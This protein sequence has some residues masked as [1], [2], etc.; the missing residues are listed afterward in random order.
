MALPKYDLR[1]ISYGNRNCPTSNPSK[2]PIITILRWV[3]F[4]PAALIGCLIAQIVFGAVGRS[5]D[6]LFGDV[7]AGVIGAI[8]LLVA[9][10]YV[11][12]KPDNK[13][14]KWV[15]MVLMILIGVIDFLYG[16]TG[17]IRGVATVFTGLAYVTHEIKD[18]YF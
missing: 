6:P 9:G 10:Q 13:I 8:A 4:I 18:E 16:T 12:G 2:T 11:L 7:I 3:G 15:L 5:W 14:A 17:T 1:P